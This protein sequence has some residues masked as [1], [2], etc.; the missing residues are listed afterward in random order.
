M[1]RREVEAVIIGTDRICANGDVVNKVGSYA[2][3]L[4]ALATSRAEAR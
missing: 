3:A 4:A 2:H 1:A